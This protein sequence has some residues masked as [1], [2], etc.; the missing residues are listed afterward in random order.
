MN[1]TGGE[2]IAAEMCGDIPTEGYPVLTESHPFLWKAVAFM[3]NRTEWLGTVTDLLADMG[4][5]YLSL[6]HISE[7]TR[8]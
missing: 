5:K 7:P 6:I 8:P 3:E 4:D 1:M 2:R